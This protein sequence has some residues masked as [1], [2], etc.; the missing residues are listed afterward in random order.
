MRPVGRPR[1]LFPVG[2][3][4]RLRLRL[5]GRGWLAVLTALGVLAAAACGGSAGTDPA[6]GP[7]DGPAAAGAV[8]RLAL[9]PDHLWD[10]LNDSGALAEWERANGV[11]VE[12]SQ[13]FDQFGAF[14]GGHADIVV[15]N[16]MDVPNIEQQSGRE[17]VIIG[18]YTFD[19]SFIGVR[20]YSSAETLA[21]LGG[22]RIAVYSPVESTLLWGVMADGLHDLQLRLDGGD[23]DMVVAEPVRLADLVMRGDADACICL[24]DFSVSYLAD[25][26][27]KALYEGR[28]AA[29][30][31]AEEM[32]AD[33]AAGR[34]IAD[35]F[36]ADKAWYGQNTDVVDSFLSLWS[37]ALGEWQQNR[38]TLVYNYQHHFSVQ[39]D[40]EVDWLAEYISHDDWIVPSPYVSEG[41]AKTLADT[42]SQMKGADLVDQDTVEPEVIASSASAPTSGS[43]S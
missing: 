35:A 9:P 10:W 42:F 24:P 14:A 34:P 25:R 28:P 7:E 41:E 36:V 22:A 13:A 32:A 5:V 29:R 8:V 3:R 19:R 27:L 16:A 20:R 31:Y 43:G 11:R 40:E 18:K 26:E 33:P 37:W 39:G 1:R 17:A 12:A 4:R 21:D 38:S 23:F 6:A 15:I 2:G 30:L